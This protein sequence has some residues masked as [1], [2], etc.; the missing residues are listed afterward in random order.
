[1]A[2]GN[3][4]FIE[5]CLLKMVIFHGKPISHGNFPFEDFSKNGFKEMNIILEIS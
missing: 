5:V 3:G 2:M 1:M 4:P